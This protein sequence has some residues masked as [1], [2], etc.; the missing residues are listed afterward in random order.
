MLRDALVPSHLL[1]L[2]VVLLLLFGFKRLP[3]MSRSLMR[4]MHIMKDEARKLRDD[5]PD[6]ESGSGSHSA[7]HSSKAQSEL[8]PPAERSVTPPAAAPRAN[9]VHT[10]TAPSPSPFVQSR[11]GGSGD[12]G[13]QH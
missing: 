8:P 12:A 10:T 6:D 2:V 11:S 3:D 4:S 9:N 13:D 1:I 7:E 5:S